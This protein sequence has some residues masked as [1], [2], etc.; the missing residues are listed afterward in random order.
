MRDPRVNDVKIPLW[1]LRYRYVDL[2]C[3]GMILYA[4]SPFQGYLDKTG[5]LADPLCKEFLIAHEDGVKQYVQ[6]CSET[7]DEKSVRLAVARAE[8]QYLSLHVNIM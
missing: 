3:R 1:P 7:F 5:L 8:A 4:T 6:H 2:I